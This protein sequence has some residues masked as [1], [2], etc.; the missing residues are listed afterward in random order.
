M[1]DGVVDLQSTLKIG[2]LNDKV[3]AG[4]HMTKRKETL[5]TVV[6]F[7]LGGREERVVLKLL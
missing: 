2:Y 5:M 3:K 7:T 4:Q 1:A 6:V